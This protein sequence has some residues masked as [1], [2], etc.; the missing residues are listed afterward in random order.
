MSVDIDRVLPFAASSEWP[1]VG[2]TD[3]SFSTHQ[4]DDPAPPNG[5]QFPL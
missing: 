5:G 3:V 2:G 4:G 1:S